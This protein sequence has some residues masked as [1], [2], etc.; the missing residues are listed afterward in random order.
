MMNIL[1]LQCMNERTA[2]KCADQ[3]VR[4]RVKNKRFGS[5]IAFLSTMQNTNQVSNVAH[6][7]GAHTVE[8]TECDKHALLE[9]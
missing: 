5:A 8:V 9:T 7:F 2:V 4:F 3:L 6:D 1:K